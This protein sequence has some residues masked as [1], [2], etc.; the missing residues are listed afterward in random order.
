[1]TEMCHNMRNIHGQCLGHKFIIVSA[2]TDLKD[3]LFWRSTLMAFPFAQ[4]FVCDSAVDLSQHCVVD[5]SDSLIS[6]V[7]QTLP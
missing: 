6:L 4:F 3:H 5:V 2:K 7:L 1:M